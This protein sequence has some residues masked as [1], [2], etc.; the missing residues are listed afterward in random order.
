M[1]K[2]KRYVVC[3]V[4]NTFYQYCV[5]RRATFETPPDPAMP[6]I[7]LPMMR[8]AMLGEKAMTTQLM[9][10]STQASCSVLR[11]PILPPRYPPTK[12]PMKDPMLR[13][14]AEK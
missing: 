10:P 2:K 13:Q 7:I 8:T 9:T 12:P 1:F 3:M 6:L 4:N 14:L 11:G 5:T